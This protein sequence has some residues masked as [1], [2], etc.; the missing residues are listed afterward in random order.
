MT[1]TRDAN[2]FYDSPLLC[3][4][5][6]EMPAACPCPSDCY[7]K[8][9]S[10]RSPDRAALFPPKGRPVA[11]P[12]GDS[13][14]ASAEL[15]TSPPRQPVPVGPEVAAAQSYTLP[16]PVVAAV[17]ARLERVWT[18]SER[19]VGRALAV[20]SVHISALVE[21]YQRQ[22]WT[23]TVGDKSRYDA[24]FTVVRFYPQ[25]DDYTIHAD[26]LDSNYGGEYGHD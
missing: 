13:E 8:A 25:P 24:D 15:T 3:E 20:R 14:C 9:H 4:H 5:A 26:V 12:M 2:G 18:K 11:T 6:N 7:C 1:W 19:K 16:G 23:V 21:L 10:C 17:N 22:G